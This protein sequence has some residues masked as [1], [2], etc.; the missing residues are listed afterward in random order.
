M[1]VGVGLKKHAYTP[2]AYAYKK[3]LEQ[4]NVDVQLAPE[5][6]LCSD[7]EVNI[8][9][10]GLRPFWRR[11]ASGAAEV[12]EYQSLSVAP[13]PVLK[14]TVKK[15]VNGQPGGRIFLNEVVRENLGFGSSVPYI[16]RD[17]GV[18]AALFQKP[19]ACPDV[20]IV[21][22][23]SIAGRTGLVEEFQRLLALGYKLL[24]VGE[25]AAS[26]RDLFRE[27]ANV[28]FAGRVSRD[29]LPRLYSRAWAGLNYTPDL[30]PFNIQ[31]STK[32]LEYLASGLVVFSN[33][34][35][36]A[37]KFSNDHGVRFLWLDE[38]QHHVDISS[39][40]IGDDF[41]FDA[42]E[43]MWDS[44]LERSGFLKFISSV[45]E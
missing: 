3:F 40:R 4:S 35:H 15:I 7:N 41:F 43:F 1:K 5:E 38:L 18:D 13:W 20:D 27:N 31:T 17:M 21:Y 42:S 45:R 23:G 6:E 33:K 12:H 24:V 29:D 30:Y 2:E 16:L 44:I 14:D 25:V 34:Y 11:K 9:F 36:W 28:E 26:V 10:M 32:T 8:Y 39:N 22:S 37:S 19:N